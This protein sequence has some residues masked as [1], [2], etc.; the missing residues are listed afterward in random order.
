[1]GKNGRRFPPKPGQ[2]LAIAYE[3][4]AKPGHT[5]LRPDS[6]EL[7]D[8]SLIGKVG[9]A[10]ERDT[11]WSEQI[12]H[13]Y[14]PSVPQAFAMGWDKMVNY[15]ALTVK[16]FGRLITGQASMS[17]TRA[18]LPLPTWPVALPPW[19]YRVIWNF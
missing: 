5:D 14:T 16:F 3:R 2:K 10:A 12:S 17:H 13:R 4:T 8:G 11:A 9:I 6:E 15:S 1:M 19:V 7:R 18:R